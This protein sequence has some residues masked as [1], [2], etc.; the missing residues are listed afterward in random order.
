MSER[1]RARGRGR[2]RPVVPGE[3]SSEPSGAAGITA[4]TDEVPTTSTLASLVPT[5][6]IPTSSETPTSEWS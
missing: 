5:P 4:P 1:G 6:I 3:T 2:S